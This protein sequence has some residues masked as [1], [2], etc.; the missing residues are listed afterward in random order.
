M[1]AARFSSNS[2]RLINRLVA[3]TVAGTMTLLSVMGYQPPARAQAR[4]ICYAIADNNPPDDSDSGITFRDTLA[5]LDF[6]TNS[7][8]DLGFIVRA[9]DG[10]TPITNIE[11]LTSRPDFNE[12]LAVNGNE[13]GIVDPATLTFTSLGRLD[14]FPDFDAIV[15]DR[16]SPNQTRLLGVS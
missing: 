12:L 6:T 13:L 5:T 14:P 10:T 1:I 15:I 7:A 3:G 9:E 4:Q 11:A 2:S 8:N 16:N